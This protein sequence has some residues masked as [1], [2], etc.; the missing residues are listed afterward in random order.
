MT[1]SD[2][3]KVIYLW[4]PLSGWSN[5]LTLTFQK[6]KTSKRVRSK[7][8]SLPKTI[9]AKDHESSHEPKPNH[10]ISTHSLPNEPVYGLGHYLYCYFYSLHLQS[11][12]VIPSQS[13]VT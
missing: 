9:P 10:T 11:P 5:G 6:V 2:N 7:R 3:P 1:E 4:V 12:S 8:K 13:I